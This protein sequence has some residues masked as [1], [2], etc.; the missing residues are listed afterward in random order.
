MWS[1]N[2][3]WSIST[4]LLV[5]LDILLVNLSTTLAFFIRFGSS[6]PWYN[7][8]A[9]W[10]MVPLMS[11]VTFITFYMFGLYSTWKRQ[12]IENL[13]Y[14]I[15]I[16]VITLS[17][18]GMALTFW[19]RE[20]AFPRTVLILSVVIQ[21]IIMVA[22]RSLVWNISRW[23]FG[24]KKV[25]IVGAVIEDGLFLMEKFAHHTKGW[26]VVQDFAQAADLSSLTEKILQADVVVISSLV[27]EKTELIN[28]CVNSNK[29]VL[30]VPR[31]YELFIAGA[32]EQQV[33]DMLVMS[34]TPPGLK[35]AQV[36]LKRIVDV[37][38]SAILLIITSP[39]IVGLYLLIPLTSPGGAIFKQE[40]LGKNGK[41][42]QIFKFRSMIQNAEEKTGP[43]LASENDPRITSTGRV[44][45]A[46]R[47]DEL[48][49]LVNVFK[50]DMS[51][52][53]PRPERKA[54][55]DQF[56]QTNPNYSYRMSV[57]PGLTGLAQVSA[58]YSTTVE[59]KLRYDLMYVRNYSL[60]L[61]L[62]I[63][64]QTIRVVL[65]REQAKGVEVDTGLEQLTEVL[66]FSEVAATRQHVD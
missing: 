60:I 3:V 65:Q 21:V 40:R 31:V 36:V 53:G 57:K 22:G 63:L 7:F 32:E 58:K 23:F 12:S 59:D 38:F 48:P 1:S 6:P 16:S 10:N 64:L 5:G 66:D 26:Y 8:E 51:L 35:P 45:R 41:P 39:L 27:E 49:Q 52:V 34:L 15:V 9:F 54:F 19:Q 55:V 18:I 24:Q 29:E 47:L 44:I 62:K 33:D 2:K 11:F 30:V 42:Y 28:H 25:L 4:I 46:T 13:I 56:Q 17:L 50:G 20:F 43:V 61:D 14:T 37:V